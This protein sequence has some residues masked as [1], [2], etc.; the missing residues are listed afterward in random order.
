MAEKSRTFR[1][2]PDAKLDYG[3]DWNTDGY[4]ATGETISASTWTVPT[5]ITEVSSEFSGTVTKIWL[6]GGTA[7]ETY[8]IAN[9][10]TTTAGRIDER[11]FDIVVEER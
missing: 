3:I 7:G 4:L 6:S 2:D 8:T 11:S 10:I 5:G 9:R 1:K